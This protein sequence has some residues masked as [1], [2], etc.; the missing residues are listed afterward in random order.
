MKSLSGSGNL[1]FL[2]LILEQPFL[3]RFFQF[4]WVGPRQSIDFM[5]QLLR[6]EAD[7][8]LRLTFLHVKW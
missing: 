8:G 1:K 2:H 3:N 6:K 7:F 5:R 4:H